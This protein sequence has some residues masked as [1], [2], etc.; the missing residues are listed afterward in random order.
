VIQDGLALRLSNDA[1]VKA[2]VG[3]PASRTSADSPDGDN[4]VFPVQ[5]PEAAVTPYLVY[6]VITGTEECTLQGASGFSMLRLQVD[7]YGGNYGAAQ[8][9]ALAV[10]NCLKSFSGALTDSA[11]TNV[12]GIFPLGPPIDFF[13]DVPLEYRLMLEFEVWYQQ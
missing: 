9:L 13:E 8:A 12:S 10:R 6:N 2:V 5:A 3:L 11:E 4:G 1:G 7:C